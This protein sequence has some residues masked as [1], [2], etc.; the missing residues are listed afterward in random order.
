MARYT[1]LFTAP[2]SLSDLR[3]ALI[4]SLQSCG[5][6]LVYEGADYLVAKEN[7]AGIPLNRLTTVEVLI[8]PPTVENNSVRV[9]LVA[10]N[11]ELPLRQNNHCQRLFTTVSD[12]IASDAIHSLA[13]RP[14]V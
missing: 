10:K 7:P 2:Q 4:Q 12:A 5:L 6:T 9:N 8:T 14:T 13:M 11:E 1:N 3:E